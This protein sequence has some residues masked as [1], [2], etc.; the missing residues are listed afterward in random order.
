MTNET[1]SNGAAD[2]N[3]LR[4]DIDQGRTGDKIPLSDPAA[5]P[6]GTDDEAAG[7]PA[8]AARAATARHD[9]VKSAPRTPPELAQ[10]GFLTHNWPFIVM[11]VA[12]ALAIVVV[13]IFR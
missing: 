3:R 10:N 2:V 11:A 5:S 12:A 8:T 6:L 4:A 7:T 9:E 1:S 13:I